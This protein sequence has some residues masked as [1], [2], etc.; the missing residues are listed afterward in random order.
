VGFV[1]FVGLLGTVGL[2]EFE[3]LVEFDGLVDLV[4]EPVVLF[5]FF[6]GTVSWLTVKSPVNK[7]ALPAVN[8]L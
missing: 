3:G 7:T 6:L 2:V 1:G 5:D 8:V 4:L